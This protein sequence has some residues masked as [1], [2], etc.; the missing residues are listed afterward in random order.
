MKPASEDEYKKIVKSFEG[1]DTPEVK[2][3]ED[4][5]TPEQYK[6]LVQYTLLKLLGSPGFVKG[7]IQNIKKV[8]EVEANDKDAIDFIQEEVE[9]S[10][11]EIIREAGK[12]YKLI[13]TRKFDKS[14]Y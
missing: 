1:Q 9:Q 11:T 8:L 2:V 3:A 7:Y 10:M 6:K 13:L 5:H 14:K 4:D 12:K